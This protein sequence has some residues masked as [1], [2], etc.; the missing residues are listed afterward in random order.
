ML[1]YFIGMIPLYIVGFLLNIFIDKT[2]L[3]EKIKNFDNLNN[4]PIYDFLKTLFLI[5]IVIVVIFSVA[6][7]ILPIYIYYAFSDGNIL[8]GLFLSLIGAI[9]ITF[10]AIIFE[11]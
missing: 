9:A 4:G 5:I 3:V 8:Y 7:A 6:T 10:D 2:H 1:E 11:N